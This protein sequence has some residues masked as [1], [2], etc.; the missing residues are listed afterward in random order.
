M[1]T[2]LVCVLLFSCIST[3]L[4]AFEKAFE[5][6]VEFY[7][8][9][10]K[11]VYL[12]SPDLAA[13]WAQLLGR[14]CECV[15]GFP[16]YTTFTPDEVR[17][18]VETCQQAKDFSLPIKTSKFQDFTDSQGQKFYGL[19]VS[20]VYDCSNVVSKRLATLYARPL[21]D[22]HY[23]IIIKQP[24][25]VDGMVPNDND[26][27]S[28]SYVKPRK[29]PTLLWCSEPKLLLCVRMIEKKSAVTEQ[30]KIPPTAWAFFDHQGQKCTL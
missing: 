17:S 12:M 29:E 23:A 25:I 14:Y 10:G 20:F 9:S 30:T 5:F 21:S 2:I 24:R 3:P 15:D 22:A 11:L 4:K 27:I 13:G 8:R 16:H 18:V 1:L 6:E 26:L 28:F 19:D 7:K